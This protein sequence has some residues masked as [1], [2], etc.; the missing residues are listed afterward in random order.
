[1]SLLRAPQS[2]GESLEQWVA[3]R[4]SGRT[5]TPRVS[6]RQAMTHS[7]VWGATRL[8]ADLVSLMPLDVFRKIDGIKIPIEVPTPPVLVTPSQIA[9]GH[10]MDVAEWIYSS[11]MSLDQDGNVIGVITA[12]DSLGLPARIDL[13][14]MSEVTARVR[15]RQ[16]SEYKINGEKH[17]PRIIWHER[18]YTTAG[19]PIG[20]S[21]ISY[22]AM[23]LHAGIS[24]QQFAI[25]WFEGGAVP[26]AHLKNEDKILKPG[27][28]ELAKARFV[29]SVRRNEPF[30][31]GKDWTYSAVA[32][33]AS[34]SEF[35]NQMKYTDRDLVRFLGVPGDMIEVA[36]DGSTVTYAN[37]TQRNLQL[38][39]MNL[40][41]VVRR[42]ERALSRLTLGDRYVKLNRSAVLAMDDKTR[43]EVFK[44][45]IESR[46][47]TPD[48][49]RR[50]EEMPPLSEPEYS[51][52]DRLFGARTPNQPKTA[53]GA[54]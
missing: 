13:V 54:S 22:A 51:Q 5:K 42:R 20:L 21:P 17:D 47:M 27:D 52:F 6:S 30:V 44:M 40:G 11:Q 16:I 7:V 23:S 46:T 48:E 41:G 18:Q 2:R 36:Q 33:K 32:A 38:L 49:V 14:P 19:L 53:G 26:S 29:A 50:L 34:E 45:R 24:A 4:L 43:A 28:A 35:I 39:T 1:M 9:D 25:D 15:G 3:D 37:V 31:S 12:L 8:R 10:P